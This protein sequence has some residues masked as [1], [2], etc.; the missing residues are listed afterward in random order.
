MSLKTIHSKDYHNYLSN[1]VENVI[2]NELTNQSQ[3]IAKLWINMGEELEMEN[4]PKISIS[5]IIRKDIEE[6]LF[7]SQKDIPREECKY[8]SGYYFKIMSEHGWTNPEMAR[9]GSNYV[10]PLKDQEI[11]PLTEYEKENYEYI[12]LIHDTIKF[13][14]EKALSKLKTNHFMSLLDNKDVKLALHD[15][16]AQL[17]IAE[18]F[19]DHKE[20]VPVNTQHILLHCIATMSSN[21]DAAQ[22]Y[23]KLRDE[24]HTLTGKQLTK[25]RKGIVKNRLAILDPKDRVTAIMWSYLGIQCKCDVTKDITKDTS[26]GTS[27]GI[28]DSWRMVELPGTGIIFR[29]GC[30]DCQGTTTVVQPIKCNVCEVL[31]FEDD[32][33]QLNDKTKCPYCME[34][35]S[36]IVIDKIKTF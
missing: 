3:N 26:K 2:E 22:E 30:L 11:V 20:K 14:K 24:T 36:S 6:K 15:W 9:N 12:T 5:T 28:C 34:D 16:R 18:S 7:E 1:V 4:I 31:F 10:D 27:R 35:F 17:S 13:L 21:N 33:I 23:F 32:I 29:A 25:Y 8:H 19:F